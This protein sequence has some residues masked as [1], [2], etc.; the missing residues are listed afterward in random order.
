M[1]EK[2]FFLYHLQMDPKIAMKMLIHERKWF[3]ERFV[4]QK[5][6]EQEAV[7]SAKRKSKTR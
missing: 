4:Q 2:F 7:E 6:K 1:E 5:N 3:V